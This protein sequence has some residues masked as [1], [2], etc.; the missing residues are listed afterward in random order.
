MIA[1]IDEYIKA[2]PGEILPILVKIR[3]TIRRAAPG[4][5]EKISWNMPTFWQNENLIHFAVFKRHIGIYPGN[6]AIEAFAGRLV[7]YETSKGAIRL[8]L[9]KPID[10]E[11][12]SDI[13]RWR[14][15]RVENKEG[16]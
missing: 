16:K 4:A 1:T 11:L 2:Q 5:T 3:D 10:Y 8:P 9:D 13:T 12:I 7:T 14:A 15:A 6:E